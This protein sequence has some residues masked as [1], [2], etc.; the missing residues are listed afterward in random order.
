MIAPGYTALSLLSEPLREGETY[1]AYILM[2]NPRKNLDAFAERLS[3]SFTEASY[4]ASLLTM[5]GYSVFNNYSNML[6][7][8]AAIF[9]VLI[10]IGSVQP[11]A[12]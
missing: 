1:D 3:G 5:D 10:F 9:C 6:V 8:L 12:R 4:Q 11:G 2:K 7:R